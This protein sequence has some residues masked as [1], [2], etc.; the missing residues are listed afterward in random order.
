V[1]D[2]RPSGAGHPQASPHHASPHRAS[3]HWA[4]QHW[5]SQHRASQHRLDKTVLAMVV[6]TPIGP[7][8]LLA[9]D[10]R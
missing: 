3:Q 4:S 7:L 10:G 5:A 6:D 9:R 2:V 1:N 8:S